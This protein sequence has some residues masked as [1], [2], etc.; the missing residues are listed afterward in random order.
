MISSNNVQCH[1]LSPFCQVAGEVLAEADDAP[2]LCIVDPFKSILVRQ[3]HLLESQRE[4]RHPR[5]K[6][7]SI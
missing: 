2:V 6:S 7:L 4:D 3:G 1:L 5:V